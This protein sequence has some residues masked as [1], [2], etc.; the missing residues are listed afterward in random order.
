M[1][2]LL[3]FSDE[4]LKGEG[5]VS[6]TPFQHPTL[7]DVEIGGAVPYTD[8]T[9]PPMMIEELI[10]GQ[11]PWI[12]ELSKKLPRVNILKTE[13]APKGA[14]VYELIVWVQNSGELPL[15]TAMG[16]RNQH[17]GPI[18]LTIEGEGLVVLSGKQRT[19][20]NAIDAMKSR[21]L[22]WLLQSEKPQ[23]LRLTLESANAGNDSAEVR[24]GGA[25]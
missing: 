12:F 9:P 1:K 19:I 2:A 17:V 16:K 6:W 4:V 25:Q 3:S 20:L 11:V 21:K 7:D 14:T 24:L 18:I 22:T 23:T 13:I 10:T 5:F 8:S 15:P